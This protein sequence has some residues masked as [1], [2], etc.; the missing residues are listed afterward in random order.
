MLTAGWIGRASTNITAGSPTFAGSPAGFFDFSTASIQVAGAVTAAFESFVVNWANN[1]EG[2]PTLAN[3]RSIGKIRRTN[4]QFARF[5]GAIGFEDITEYTKFLAQSEM[6]VIGSWFT[7]NSFL[8]VVELPR[9][10]YTAMP[11]GMSGRGRQLV[12]I[13]GI[14]RYHTGSGNAYKVTI[15]NVSSSNVY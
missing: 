13:D 4:A 8:M 15:N 12:T 2:V 1:I 5:Q 3:T 10:V 14:A 7:T 11:L 9:V 6:Q